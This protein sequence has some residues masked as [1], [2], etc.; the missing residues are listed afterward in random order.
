MTYTVI[1]SPTAKRQIKK[2]DRKIQEK[3]V[4]KLRELAINP[5]PFGVRKLSGEK[6]I[7]RIRVED[8]RIIFKYSKKQLAVL[9]LKVGHRRE[10]YK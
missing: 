3:I 9:I 7:Y 6:S 2:L 4:E 10:I 8:N 5:F 1:I